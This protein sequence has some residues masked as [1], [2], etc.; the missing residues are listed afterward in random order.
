MNKELRDGIAI[1][2]A[3]GAEYWAHGPKGSGSIWGVRNGKY[4][5]VFKPTKRRPHYE[6]FETNFPIAR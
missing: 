3:V 1:C 6:F 5:Q 2:A 4:V